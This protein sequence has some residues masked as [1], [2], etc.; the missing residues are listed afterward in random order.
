MRLDD[1]F[2]GQT[3]RLPALP[4]HLGGRDPWQAIGTA[5]RTFE[6]DQQEFGPFKFEPPDV[7]EFELRKK[8]SSHSRTISDPN[9]SMRVIH[10]AFEA[11]VRAAV[12]S[13]LGNDH[14]L[15]PECKKRL[16]AFAELPSAY[17]YKPGS[18][19]SAVVLKHARVKGSRSSLID[20]H[21]A[22]GSV[23]IELL[24]SVITGLLLADRSSAI[25]LCSHTQA[26]LYA[27]VHDVFSDE[28]M[29][30]WQKVYALLRKFFAVDRERGIGLFQGSPTS[31][32]LFNIVCEA[33]INPPIKILLYRANQTRDPSREVVSTQFAD[34]LD[35]TAAQSVEIP[36]REIRRLIKN[37]FRINDGKVFHVNLEQN[38]A[39]ILGF[40]I[41]KDGRVVFP[42]ERRERLHVA[43]EIATRALRERDPRWKRLY[44]KA[45]GYH[46]EFATYLEMLKKMNQPITR[47]DRRTLDRLDTMTGWKPRR[48]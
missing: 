35:F 1:W 33:V 39:A 7:R 11:F 40:S 17:A 38:R 44:G 20:L 10:R 27:N 4:R 25:L 12:A 6:L 13:H 18:T 8:G 31:P 46:S 37:A 16:Q 15:F 48:D 28:E 2:Q 43:I 19:T 9:A 47:S 42:K 34:N 36:V 5:L 45:M 24:T 21:D 14:W 30:L 26:I 29:L 3:S 41:G 22:Y 23:D 32:W